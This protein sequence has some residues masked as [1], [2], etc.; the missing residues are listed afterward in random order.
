M[1]PGET[2]D[3][4]DAR[5]IDIPGVPGD[6]RDPGDFRDP[7][8]PPH[9]FYTRKCS[10]FTTPKPHSAVILVWGGVVFVTIYGTMATV[11]KNKRYGP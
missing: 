4:R 9:F 8:P 6:H 11:L 2:I 1:I 5:D 10:V 3:P 7:P